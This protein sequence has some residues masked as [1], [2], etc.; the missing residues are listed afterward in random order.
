MGFVVRR[1]SL[2]SKATGRITGGPHNTVLDI[3]IV[4]WN[5]FSLIFLIVI[6]LIFGLALIDIITNNSYSILIMLIP[7]FLFFIIFPTVKMR[8][9]LKRFEEYLLSDIKKFEE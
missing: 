8:N 1:S 4:G 5:W 9:G 2:F 6:S 7:M 3:S